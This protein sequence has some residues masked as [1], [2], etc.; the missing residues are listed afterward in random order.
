MLQAQV[1]LSTTLLTHA[2]IYTAA[3]QQCGNAHTIESWNDGMTPNIR[4]AVVMLY[5]LH[6]MQAADKVDMTHS[7][8]KT[9]DL[10]NL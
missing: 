8:C 10:R 5:T 7:L 3:M 6:T 4:S 2:H 9:Q 1:A